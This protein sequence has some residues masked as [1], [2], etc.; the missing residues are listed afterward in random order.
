MGTDAADI[1]LTRLACWGAG[2]TAG[3]LPGDLVRW[4]R[5]AG[6]RA[7][8][9]AA[10][11][12][13][14]GKMGSIDQVGRK[15]LNFSRLREAMY[16]TLSSTQPAS[17][18]QTFGSLPYVM[19]GFHA[20]A[21]GATGI[22]PRGWDAIAGYAHVK[23]EICRLLEWPTRHADAWRT[24]ALPRPRG[25]LLHGPSGCGKTTL[26]RGIASA[27]PSLNVLEVSCATLMSPILGEAESALRGAAARA[28]SASPCVLLLDEF[29][30]IAISRSAAS[31]GGA[32]LAFG[33][34][35]WQ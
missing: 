23:T 17:L 28:R 9:I 14:A 18:G 4:C 33:R 35:A 31:G 13:A 12:T 8:A 15:Q 2:R 11:E 10:A 34:L 16:S 20:R 26:A 3:Y 1:L 5:R 22:L 32:S 7:T 30:T 24:L 6:V 27:L 29:D 25:I 19:S 21:V